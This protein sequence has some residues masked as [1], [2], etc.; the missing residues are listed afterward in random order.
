[1]AV[2]YDSKRKSW[3]FTIDL[4]KGRDGKRRQMRRR[5]FKTEKLAER[6]EREARAQF[7]N[8]NLAE[9]GTVAAELVEWLQ[10]RELDVAITTLQ[11][12]NCQVK[13]CST[14]GHDQ[15]V[16]RTHHSYSLIAGGLWI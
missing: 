4:P 2:N 8:A 11:I 6:A 12:L 10:E 14:F 7:G 15:G 3:E 9:D 13:I 1:M 16:I 5:G